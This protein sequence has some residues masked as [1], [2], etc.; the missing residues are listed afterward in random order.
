MEHSILNI[1]FVHGCDRCVVHEPWAAHQIHGIPIA[2][3]EIRVGR[4]WRLLPDPHYVLIL[5]AALARSK[6]E[7]IA[8]IAEGDASNWWRV[9]GHLP[10]GAEL[11]LAHGAGHG[12]AL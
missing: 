4:H 1:V 11:V 8:S 6:R 5:N 9:P 2:Q 3:P 7:L 12:D 10:L